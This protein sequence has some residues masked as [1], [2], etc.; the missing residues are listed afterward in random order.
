MRARWPNFSAASTATEWK[1]NVL[2]SRPV[3]SSRLELPQKFPVP[4]DG[5]QRQ[6]LGIAGISGDLLYSRRTRQRATRTATATREE[7]AAR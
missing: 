1:W 7:Q 5:F 3:M 2:I 4:A 6:R